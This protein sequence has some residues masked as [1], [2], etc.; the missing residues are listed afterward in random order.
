MP[1]NLVA[2]QLSSKPQTH[3]A[4]VLSAIGQKAYADNARVVFLK[5]ESSRLAEEIA[6]VPDDTQ[7]RLDWINKQLHGNL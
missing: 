2:R 7:S 6:N 4:A 3:R 5:T 1:S